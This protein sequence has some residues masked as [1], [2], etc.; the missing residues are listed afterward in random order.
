MRYL[1][2]LAHETRAR[3]M[4]ARRP[5]WLPAVDFLA[6]E[7][8]RA[9]PA[10]TD[11]SPEPEATPARATADPVRPL[12]VETAGRALAPELPAGKP[13]A[14]VTTPFPQPIHTP[15]LSPSVSAPPA[16]V[17]PRQPGDRPEPGRER[18]FSQP[19]LRETVSPLRVQTRHPGEP[20]P[21]GRPP[22]FAAPI[23]PA[24]AAPRRPDGRRVDPASA[25]F[26]LG[27][28]Q[29]TDPTPTPADRPNLNL[30]LAEIARRQ[31]E[32]ERAYLA[33][34]SPSSSEPAPVSRSRTERG[35]AHPDAQSEPV[36]LNIGS[37]VVQM[38]PPIAAAAP[39]PPVRPLPPAADTRR[40][41]ARS[42]LDR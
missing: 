38:E 8:A 3:V 25:Q 14:A 18:D 32:L 16:P 26:D 36:S 19:G 13:A 12:P 27:P 24:A 21:S 29:R 17:A 5:A 6:D 23:E 31:S 37:I 28:P 33:R 10:S 42:F 40:R 39:P 20:F 22:H 9:A 41:W 35:D 11:G 1:A 34:P 4:P 7:N 15:V 30:V 2:H